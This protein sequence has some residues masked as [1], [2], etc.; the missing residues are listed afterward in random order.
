MDLGTNPYE[1]PKKSQDSHFFLKKSDGVPFSE[2]KTGDE[3][4]VNKALDASANIW[5]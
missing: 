2:K 5:I 3:S 4:A 1:D